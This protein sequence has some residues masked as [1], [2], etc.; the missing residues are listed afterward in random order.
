MHPS[1]QQKLAMF[2]YMH[3]PEHLQAVSKPFHSLAHDVAEKLHSTPAGPQLTICLQ[4]L[5]E[6]KD[7]AVRAAIAIPT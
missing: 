4:K 7:E 1:I 3:L 2:G 6:A 5:L